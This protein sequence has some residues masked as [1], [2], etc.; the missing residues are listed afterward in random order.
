MNHHS[1]TSNCKFAL[2]ASDWNSTAQKRQKKSSDNLAKTKNPDKKRYYNIKISG[3]VIY[4]RNADKN[5]DAVGSS[6]TRRSALKRAVMM[7]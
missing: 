4:C 5:N 3:C 6:T 1:L 7:V 2:L